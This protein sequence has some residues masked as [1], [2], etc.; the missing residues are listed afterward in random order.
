M[1]AAALAAGA[2]PAAAASMTVDDVISKHIEAHGGA[3]RWKQIR[4][5]KM[6]GM[7]TSW[8]K[9]APFTITKT[10]DG[11]FHLDGVQDEKKLEIGY[12]GSI[13]WW[14]NR[15]MGE[16]AQKIRGADLPVV[17]RETDFPT[18]FF[19]YKEKKHEVKLVGPK[20]IEGREALALEV[21][22]ADGLSETWYLDPKTF[23]EVARESPGSDFGRPVPQQTFYEDFRAVDG[24]KLPFRIDSQWYTRERALEIEKIETNVAVDDAGF[25]LPP[26]VGMGPLQPMAGEW[27]VTLQRRNGEGAPWRDGE[28]ASRIESLL[29]GALLQESYASSEGAAVM[30]TFSFDKYRKRYRITDKNDQQTYLDVLD[31]DFNEEKKLV[32]D[33][34]ST[35]TPALMFG[36]T[37]HGRVAVFDITA[38]GFK[39]DEDYSVDGGK[40][41]INV[42]KSTYTRKK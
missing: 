1:T 39:I 30:R 38:D 24:V 11:R 25:K 12:D 5:L 27:K 2:F 13:A 19:D 16:G 41:W 36:Q 20:A 26:P 40:T 18:P 4:S 35:N 8:S 6:T 28:R 17:L 34:V 42:L 37:I 23:L 14:D 3:A 31:G 9:K 29:G 21:K 32:A 10:S 22:R 33:D 7:M 15:M